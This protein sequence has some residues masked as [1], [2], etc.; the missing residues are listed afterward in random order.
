MVRLHHD[1]EYATKGRDLSVSLSFSPLGI[2]GHAG[3]NTNLT[4]QT[5]NNK[6]KKQ[7]TNKCFKPAGKACGCN[8][9]PRRWTPVQISG[10]KRDRE[11]KKKRERERKEKEKEKEKRE[12]R[13]KK[14]RPFL[15]YIAASMPPESPDHGI[16]KHKFVCVVYCC[17]LL[18]CCVV[19]T[20]VWLC[21]LCCV[22]FVFVLL[23][24]VFCEKRLRFFVVDRTA[25]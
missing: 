11:I 16:P 4:S 17:L 5:F 12:K 23:L 22:C 3:V 8:C 14:E 19:A 7:K 1:V 10:K 18:C 6:T 20:I 15:A 21:C 24:T 25:L 9:R 13:R 2:C